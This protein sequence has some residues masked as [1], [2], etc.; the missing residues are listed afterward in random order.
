MLDTDAQ[1]P[2]QEPWLH[3]ILPQLAITW[4]A[5]AMLEGSAGCSTCFASQGGPTRSAPLRASAA[6][7][8]LG[9]PGGG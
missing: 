3:N 5:C 4:P 2:G 9:L 6:A 8:P 7:A 1:Q